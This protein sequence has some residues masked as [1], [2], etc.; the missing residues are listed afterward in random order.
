[1]TFFYDIEKKTHF[2]VNFPLVVVLCGIFL[3]FDILLLKK[4]FFFDVKF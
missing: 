2:I 4:Y 3:F 1:M